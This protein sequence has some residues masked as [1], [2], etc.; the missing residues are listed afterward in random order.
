MKVATMF[1]RILTTILLK[2]CGCSNVKPYKMYSSHK[3]MH[4]RMYSLPNKVHIDKAKNT[5][6]NFRIAG[7][8][9]IIRL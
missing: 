6:S 4:D 1:S 7:R 3:Y 8:E 9:S 5:F 2:Q